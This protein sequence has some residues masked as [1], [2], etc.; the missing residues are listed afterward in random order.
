[1]CILDVILILRLFFV[2]VFIFIGFI[3]YVNMIFVI[4]ALSS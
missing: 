3:I 4:V 1:M 2:V